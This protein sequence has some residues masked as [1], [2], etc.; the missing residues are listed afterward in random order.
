MER[1]DIVRSNYNNKHNVFGAYSN[2]LTYEQS[3]RPAERRDMADIEDIRIN[4]KH[5]KSKRIRSFIDQT[6]DP[7]C[8][9]YGGAVIEMAYSENGG[10]LQQ[11]IAAVLM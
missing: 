1:I 6:G 5:A 7:Y 2:M 3:R 9:K 10:S 11:N 4:C 8:L